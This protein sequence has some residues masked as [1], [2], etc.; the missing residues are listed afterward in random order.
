MSYLPGLINNTKEFPLIK[1]SIHI[2]CHQEYVK[3]ILV[4]E[5]S[6]QSYEIFYRDKGDD[7]L[8]QLEKYKTFSVQGED[9]VGVLCGDSKHILTKAKVDKNLEIGVWYDKDYRCNIEAV[10]RVYESFKTFT[11]QLKKELYVY[12]LRLQVENVFQLRSILPCFD[13][14]FLVILGI[15][16]YA[17]KTPATLDFVDIVEMDHWKNA[18]RVELYGFLISIPIKHFCH[19]CRVKARVPKISA[20]DIQTLVEVNFGI[21]FY[22]SS[23]T[24]SRLISTPHV[25]AI[26]ICTSITL[27]QM[28]HNNY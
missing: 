3:L 6:A 13:P 16:N 4:F 5:N 1:F 20:D 23:K 15:C 9:Y 26:S 2:Q 25:F 27:M 21:L 7:T 12:Y 11:Q 14:K 8:V 28:L 10:D 17:D 24:N 18:K 19:F 22:F